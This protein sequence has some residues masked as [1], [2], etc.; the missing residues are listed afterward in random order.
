[1]YRY[2]MEVVGAAVGRKKAAHAGMHDL[3]KMENRSMIRIGG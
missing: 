1:L 3:A 2:I